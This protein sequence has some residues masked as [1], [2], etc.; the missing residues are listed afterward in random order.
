MIELVALLGT[1]LIAGL[2]GSV[3]CVGMCAGISG[4]YAA[5]TVV[6]IR[7][8]WPLALAYNLGRI[9]SYAV[10][11]AIVGIFGATIVSLLP[12]LATPARLLSGALIALIGIQ[13]AFSVQLL[14]PLER[15]GATLWGKIAPVA[16]RCVPANTLVKALGLGLLWGWLP[17]GL[18]YSVLLIAATSAEPAAASGVMI[19]FGVGTLPAM[20]VTGLGI[21]KFGSTMKRHRRGAGV[22]LILV[23]IATALMPALSLFSAGHHSMH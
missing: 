22:V 6:A 11:G 9:L 19:A 14:A 20:L 8:Q 12:A 10:I 17:C 4:L 21:A 16:G 13:I 1:A 7:T 3:H 18:V 23:G 5:G 2:L 15:I